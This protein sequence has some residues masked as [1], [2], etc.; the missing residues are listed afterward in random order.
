MDVNGL[1]KVNDQ[2]GHD[3][4]D[5]LLKGAS[6][7]ISRCFGSYGKAYRT[8][9]DEFIAIVDHGK[10]YDNFDGCLK[11]FQEQLE[12]KMISFLDVD[13]PLSLAIGCAKF[14]KGMKFSEVLHK[15]DTNMYLNK[16]MIKEKY[17]F[18]NR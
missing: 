18:G 5:E 3:A 7:C 17:H 9:G 10:D 16:T 14:E 13:M 15:A 4:G 2:L 6:S 8:G 11:A 1:K 12:C